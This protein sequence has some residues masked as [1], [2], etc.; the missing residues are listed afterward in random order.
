MNSI[1]KRVSLMTFIILIFIIVFVYIILLSPIIKRQEETRIENFEL[2]VLI[3]HQVLDEFVSKKIS[4]T[5]SLSSQSSSRDAI[6]DYE[7]QKISWDELKD[8]TYEKYRDGIE[9][10]KHYEY[11]ARWVDNKL[12][13]S[14][15]DEKVLENIRIP[16]LTS[17]IALYD[18][19]KNNI[20]IV[21][22]IL[23]GDR[24]LGYDIL[25]VSMEATFEKIRN[26]DYDMWIETGISEEK[27][28]RKDG[29][30]TVGK[31]FDNFFGTF[32]ATITE[33]ELFKDIRDVELRIFIYSVLALTSI[34]ILLDFI[35]LKYSKKIVRQIDTSRKEV[36]AREIE[37][38]RLINEMNKGF[39]VFDVIRNQD[40]DS[41][42]YMFKNINR[43][44]EEIT[45]MSKDYILGRTLDNVLFE[46]EKNWVKN[47]DYVIY[48]ETTVSF[49]VHMDFNNKWYRISAYIPNDNQL[50]LMMDDITESI[51]VQ[52]RLAN[53]EQQMRLT[54]DV[55][56]EGIWDWNMKDK[57][58]Y[59][60]RKWCEIVGVDSML[61]YHNKEAFNQFVH[62]DD[63]E[64]VNACL[65]YA[66]ENDEPYYSEH[67]ILRTD[68]TIIWVLDRGA[69]VYDDSSD[70]PVRM[71]G[72]ILNV[73]RRKETEEALS[74]EK[75]IFK[76]TLLSVGD[77]VI[78]TDVNGY[79]NFMNLE[80]ERITKWDDEE[81]HG[82]SLESVYKLIDE[83][84]NSFIANIIEDYM[85]AT[86]SGLNRKLIL[87]SKNGERIPVQ[88]TIAPI[89]EE[90]EEII[91]GFVIAFRNVTEQR[92]RQRQI[93]ELSFHDYLTGLY[94]RR[95]MEDSIRRLDT[96]RNIP[97]AIMALDI[98]GL[99]MAN[100]TFGHEVGD[101]LI[102]AA[103]KVIK[104]ACREEDIVA[105][106]GG[107][108]F[109][110][111]LPQTKGKNVEA[112]KQRILAAAKTEYVQSIGV[113]IAVGYSVKS[114][115]SEDI[116]ETQKKADKHMYKNKM[117]SS[118]KMKLSMINMA[119]EN[120]QQNYE[121]EE[122]HTERVAEYSSKILA[123]MNYPQENV[124][125]IYIAGTLHDIG[126]I[127]LPPELLNKKEA[128]TKEEIEQV[129]RY[130]G[131]GYQI[132]K[133]TDEYSGIAEIV[134]YHHERYD[135]KGYPNGLKREEIPLESRIISVADAYESMTGVRPYKR[136]MSQEDAIQELKKNSGSQFDPEIVDIFIHKVLLS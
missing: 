47:L 61:E 62:P 30:I 77:G 122:M 98:N 105:R 102:R 117:K 85:S 81:V 136:K 128:L 125:E 6:A 93:E 3:Q 88:E 131:A 22:P 38:R 94:N 12:L 83:E 84:Q 15:G 21:N 75:E 110:V 55:I 124:D 96:N 16:Y 51:K 7:K 1:N 90:N 32:Y 121:A 5:K 18:K 79:I 107:D 2:N 40:N 133:N 14:F 34:F 57:R 104:S 48:E 29:I 123:A 115:D 35:V 76:T 27:K 116:Y 132:L 43:T 28:T 45:G 33:E 95:Y 23:K 120:I 11:I 19:K 92:E 118:K 65:N 53:S 72:S 24:F 68:G 82:K 9:V 66:L 127:I 119:M 31:S 36:V 73:T 108:E 130:P 41:I 86:E 100:D 71:I 17:T 59:H 26:R 103:A 56:G 67:R 112:I 74:K 13:V 37:N 44:F 114:D 97:I 42:K 52:N 4:E 25:C 70:G 46:S 80:A 113:S 60:N 89:Q 10:I 135:G 78:A 54:L 106:T 111:L 50:A 58:V 63:R 109:M 101:Q 20:I 87:E 91:T 49:Q 99:K 8:I 69:L 129:H 39:V 64:K 134:L 126:K